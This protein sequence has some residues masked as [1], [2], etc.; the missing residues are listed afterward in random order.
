MRHFRYETDD[1]NE[2]WWR[3]VFVNGDDPR[4]R[5]ACALSQFAADVRRGVRVFM[6]ER[7][8]A[9]RRRCIQGWQHYLEHGKP[10]GEESAQ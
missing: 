7:K 6:N 4:Y 1:P 2:P 5:R 3:E 9:Y 8:L 10:P